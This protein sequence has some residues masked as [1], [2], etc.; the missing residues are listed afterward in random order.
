[1]AD[2][3][4]LIQLKVTNADS[5]V[6]PMS[7]LNVHFIANEALRLLRQQLQGPSDQYGQPIGLSGTVA[8]NDEAAHGQILSVVDS[9]VRSTQAS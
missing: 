6:A 5:S 2:T 7:G 8:V 1:M 3:Y 9:A 4:V